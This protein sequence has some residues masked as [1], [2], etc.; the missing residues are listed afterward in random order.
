[1]ANE[2]TS[3]REMPIEDAQKL[4]AMMLFGEK[5]G[6]EVRV[7]DIGTSRELCG[8]THVARTGDIGLFRILSEGGVA[9]GIRRVEAIAGT[10]AIAHAQAESE[11]LARVAET[12]RAQPQELEARLAQILESVRAL[13]KEVARLKG[14]LAMGR[15]DDMLESGTRMV[16]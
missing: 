8:G 2:A 13:E 15:L 14:Q 16:K 4:G 7:L 6:D 11:R 9:A 5:Y 3:A 12:L 1:L 10:V